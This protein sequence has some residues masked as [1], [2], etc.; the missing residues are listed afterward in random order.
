MCA[1]TINHLTT[2]IRKKSNVVAIP[3]PPI[4]VGMYLMLCSVTVQ[5]SLSP[6]SDDG[7]GSQLVERLDR[8][9]GQ[10]VHASLQSKFIQPT[11]VL[12]LATEPGNECQPQKIF[13][14]KLSTHKTSR[15]T[16]CI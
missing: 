6:V 14:Y 4:A 5:G 9:R 16:V 7:P 13:L 1:T 3:L 15:S 10:V 11:I 12:F 8:E 2:S